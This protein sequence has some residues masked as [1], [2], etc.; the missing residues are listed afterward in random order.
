ML[1]GKRQ[2]QQAEIGILLPGDEAP[3]ARLVRVALAR[4]ETV[5]IGEVA[6]A[7]LFQELLLF[8]ELKIH[9]LGPNNITAVIP[10]AALAAVRNP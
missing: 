9:C 5:M 2:A 1:F 3:A 8:G 10:E 4:L 6:F 7:A